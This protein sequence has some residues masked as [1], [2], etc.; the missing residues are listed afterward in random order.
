MPI[1]IVNFNFAFY[2]LFKHDNNNNK[3]HEKLKALELDVIQFVYA[4][5]EEQTTD[6][7]PQQK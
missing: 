5:L 6:K 3:Q 7:N 4:K 2:T 1:I